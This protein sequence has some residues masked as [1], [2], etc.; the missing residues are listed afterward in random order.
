MP[1]NFD[2]TV[3]LVNSADVRGI[4]GGIMAAASD[5]DRVWFEQ[6]MAD[7]LTKA[8]ALDRIVSS[9][10]LKAGAATKRGREQR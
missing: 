8:D 5:A 9:L 7:G 4:E 2:V 1:D 6:M 3:I 10:A